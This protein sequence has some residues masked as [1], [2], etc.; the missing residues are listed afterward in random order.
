MNSNDGDNSEENILV[1][2][3]NR[4]LNNEENTKLNKVKTIKIS[5]DYNKI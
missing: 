5:M 3:E 2:F 1:L 4:P